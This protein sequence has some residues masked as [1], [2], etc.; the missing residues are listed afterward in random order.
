M[1]IRFSS[2]PGI[3]FAQDK[4]GQ[5]WLP[6]VALV[7]LPL[8]AFA[9]AVPQSGDDRDA[10]Q[11]VQNEFATRFAGMREEQSDLLETHRQ[12]QV[13]QQ[14]LQDGFSLM[15]AQVQ[16]VKEDLPPVPS[17]KVAQAE[18]SPNNRGVVQLLNQVEALNGELNRLRGQMEVLSNDVNNAQKRQRDMYVDLDTRLRRI[19]QG[20]AGKKDADNVSALEERIR[21][22]E[23]GSATPS[24]I[25]QPVTSAA[26]VPVNPPPPAATAAAAA[27]SAAAASP[28]PSTANPGAPAAS[29][30]SSS[31]PPASLTANDPAA[32]QRSYDN[33]YSN[34]RL[35][36]YPSAIRGF[37]AF[38]K[39]YPKHALA[40]N[41]QYWIGES[42]AHMKQYR[43]AIDAERRLLGTYPDSNKAPDALLIIGTAEGN[44]G[45]NA[46]ARKTYE[47]LVAKYPAS[48]AADKA[49]GRLA[50]LK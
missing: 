4:R 10:L 32:I 28:P 8:G 47:E 15:L 5:R 31:L 1:V 13:S 11:E 2:T 40:A 41:A 50:K 29:S 9:A 46:A 20:G 45:D 39:S 49:K 12:L 35:S 7:L 34:Y 26:T 30:S 22:L 48:D 36:D 23:Q 17:Q 6:L 44:L 14:H 19:E 43:D 24:S 37:E 25:P 21:K 38:L 3:R 42:Y 27:A 18:P 16:T 33:A